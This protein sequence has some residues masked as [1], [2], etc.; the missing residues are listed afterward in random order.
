M[1]NKL[2]TLRNDQK[3]KK[4]RSVRTRKGKKKIEVALEGGPGGTVA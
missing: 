2:K 1:E 4:R 3:T